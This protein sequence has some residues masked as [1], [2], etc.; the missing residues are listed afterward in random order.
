[1][2]DTRVTVDGT[3]YTF[4]VTDEGAVSC[5]RSGEPWVNFEAGSKALIALV[6]EAHGARAEITVLR[7][8]LKLAEAPLIEV[9]ARYNE[10]GPRVRENIDLTMP[11]FAAWRESMEGPS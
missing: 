9:L 8:Q 6:H 2:S 1:M 11:A 10:A 4:V 7:Q 3:K 5:L